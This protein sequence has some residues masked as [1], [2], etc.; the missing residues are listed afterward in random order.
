MQLPDDFI[1][2]LV[3]ATNDRQKDKGGNVIYGTIR[4]DGTRKY[5]QIDGSSEYTPVETTVE[6]AAGDR[7]SASIKNHTAM[8]TGNISDPAIGTKT[9]DG[10]RSSIT[11]TAA[12]IRMELSDEV[13]KMNSSF[14]LTAAEIRSELSNEVDGLKSSI[15]QNAGNIEMMVRKQDEFSKFQQTVEGFS[16]MGNGGSVKISSGDINLTGRITFKELSN[17]VTNKMDSTE[18]TANSALNVANG[19]SNTA[20]SAYSRAGTAIAKANTAQEAADAA[21]E[22]ALENELPNYLTSTY[23]SSTTIMSP[24]IVGGRFYAAGRTSYTMMTSN[25]LY[26]YSDGATNPKVELS[27]T[28]SGGSGVVQMILG[29]GSYNESEYCNRLYVEKSSTSAG[30]YYYNESGKKTGFSFDLSGK[31]TIYRAGVATTL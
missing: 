17:D 14:E 7:V 27:F 18:N 28:N 22:L 5:I 2:Q 21:Y 25:G 16:F 9:A 13:N 26:V 1:T 23:I 3:K 31:I 6:I 30:I 11:Q 10:L 8:V 4:D 15:T 24:S 29:V 12:Q 20:S 19:A